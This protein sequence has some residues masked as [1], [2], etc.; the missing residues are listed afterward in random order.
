MRETLSP[1]LV[2]LLIC[3]GGYVMLGRSL[4]LKLPHV[5]GKHGLLH[6]LLHFLWHVL[7]KVAHLAWHGLKLLIGGHH[8]SSEGAAFL[9]W[10]ERRRLLNGHHAGLTIDGHHGRLSDEDSFL[11]LALVAPTGAGKTTRFIIPNLFTLEHCSIVVTDPSGEIHARTSGHLA[12]RGFDILVV[13]PANASASLRYNPLSRIKTETQAQEI[14]HCLI[15]SAN[16]DYDREPFWNSG[17]ERILDVFIRTLKA[18]GK[19][20][21]LNLPNV[22]HLLQHFGEDGSALDDFI[23]RHADEATYQQYRAFVGGNPKVMQSWISVATNSLALLNNPDVA[24]FMA[25]DDL[26][27]SALRKRPTVVYLMLPSDKISFYSFIMNLFYTQLFAACMERLPGSKDLPVYCLM[28][29]FGH[30]SIPFF[31]TIITTIRKYRVSLSLVLQSVSQLA[32]NYGKDKAAT[33]LEG[34]VSSRLFYSGLDME[35]AQR[36]ER[37]LGR[38]RTVTERKDGTRQVQE[39]NLMNADRIRTMPDDQALFVFRNKEPAQLH[40]VPYFKNSHHSKAA[41]LPPH[42]LPVTTL[43]APVLL[44]PLTTDEEHEDA[45]AAE[46]TV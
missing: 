20:E 10:F 6:H 15:R 35:S 34:D 36:V 42:P 41:K 30:S 46:A 5:W 27:F 37:L 3:Y 23:A 33:I 7:E 26:D 8:H 43:Q 18:M 9:S 31:E 21:F 29:E 22:L 2:I 14:A 11:H 16:K 38:K 17:A 45:G 19:P 44:V 13:N 40:T 1:I 12:A 28:D 4:G 25:G 39:G 24:R 32:T